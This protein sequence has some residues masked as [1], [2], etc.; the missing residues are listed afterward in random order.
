MVSS[1]SQSARGCVTP[2]RRSRQRG[3]TLLLL[4]LFKGEDTMADSPRSPGARPVRVRPWRVM[5]S[6][7]ALGSRSGGARAPADDI[8]Q[9][10]GGD[11]R[12]YHSHGTALP[13][14]T[15]AAWASPRGAPSDGFSRLPAR[16]L[17]TIRL[18]TSGPSWKTLL[19][20][21]RLRSTV[22]SSPGAAQHQLAPKTVRS[23]GLATSLPGLL[24]VSCIDAGGLRRCLLAHLH[25]RL[26]LICCGPSRSVCSERCSP[27]GDLIQVPSSITQV[28]RHSL[29][30][31]SFNSGSKTN[32]YLA[33][34]C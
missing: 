17:H 3:G 29:V 16:P 27:L 14:S 21:W 28:W 15:P 31:G 33:S 9:I 34:S 2:R 18:R 32:P 26:C 5:T 24:L 12:S 1:C 22:H 25:Y 11:W 13:T 4:V 19:G 30:Y 10:D 7:P 23:I 6:A 20:V 8:T